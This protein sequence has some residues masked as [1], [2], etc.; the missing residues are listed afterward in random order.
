MSKELTNDE[1]IQRL[2]EYYRADFL[3]FAADCLWIRPK[4]GGLVRFVPNEAQ[5]DFIDRFIT[6]MEMKGY[7][8][9]IILK[10]RQMGFST[11]IE[12]LIYWWTI[13]HAGTKSLVLTHL[14]SSTKELFEI[15]KRYHDYTPEEFKTAASRASVNELAF[16]GIDCA[17]KTA[18]AGSKNVGHGSTIQCLHWS[19]V[20]R[21]K[22][23]EDMTA[24]VMQ[25]VPTGE[26]SMI[27]LESTANGP[28]DYFHSTWEAALR[29]ESEFE[30]VFY[31]WTVMTEYAISAEGV[32]FSEEELAYQQLHNITDEQLAW[33]QSK[34]RS[35]KGSEERKIALFAEQYPITAEEAF[36]SAEG[37]LISGDSVTKA[38]KAKYEPIGP[39]I[40]GV[41]PARR[42][43]D[44]TGIVIRQGRKVVKTIRLKIPNTMLVAERCAKLIT[45][46]N[47]DAVFIDT[48]GIGAG[49]YDRLEQLGYKDRIFEAIASNTADNDDA[50][51]NKR[52][53]MWD[54]MSEWLDAGADIPDNDLFASDLLLPKYDHD[55]KDRLLLEPKKKMPRS[56]DVGDALAMTFYLKNVVPRSQQPDEYEGIR[57]TPTNGGSM[58]N[59]KF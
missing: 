25:T 51:V 44:S 55:S 11:L 13:N 16:T 18:T 30:P 32:K 43:K 24:G 58:L 41:D 10:A 1:I 3:R 54:R 33:R 56:P 46:F 29:G 27:F 53:E 21:S 5:I 8:R 22:N 2:S 7:A 45:E 23:Q 49:V 9:F 31:P 40:M 59:G 17:I 14:D 20:S 50:Y 26:G 57:R 15:T 39:I 38:R 6:A 19:E 35:F 52:A 42:G 28:G 47:A 36:Q 48:I 4:K 37:S 12:A 34:I